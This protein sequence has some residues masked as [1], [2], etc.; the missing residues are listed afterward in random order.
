[1]ICKLT[2]SFVLIGLSFWN[3]YKLVASSGK[4]NVT[5]WRPSVR[6]SVPSF[7]LTLTDSVAQRDSP[8]TT[9][10]AVSVHFRHSI[11][12]TDALVR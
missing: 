7:Y 3:Y 10:Y 5:V 4:R 9:L 1:M 6:P 12:R 11:T 2:L 8:R